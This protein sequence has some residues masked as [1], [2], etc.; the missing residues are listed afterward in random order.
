M[1]RSTYKPGH[2]PVDP[3]ALPELDFVLTPAER[4]IAVMAR[5][6]IIGMNRPKPVPVSNVARFTD[7]TPGLAVVELSED[8]LTPAQHRALF[9]EAP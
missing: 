7:F 1:T 8:D 4:D 2:D 6:E 3:S 9:G 5:A